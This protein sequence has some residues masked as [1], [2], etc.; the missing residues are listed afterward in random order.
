[1]CRAVKLRITEDALKRIRKNEN[2]VEG[3][4]TRSVPCHYC[5]HNTIVLY[6]DT[7]GHFKQKCSKCS[8]EGVYYALDYRRPKRTLSYRR[9]RKLR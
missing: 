7:A 5:C 6:P 8:N 4:K 3:M 1:M 9:I 2:N